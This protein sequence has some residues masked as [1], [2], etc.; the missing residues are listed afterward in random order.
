[1]LLL[2]VLSFAAHAGLPTVGCDFQHQ[3]CDW[4]L[5]ARGRGERLV[6][7]VKLEI[8]EMYKTFIATY[9]YTEGII[10]TQ[11]IVGDKQG[12]LVTGHTEVYHVTARQT[13]VYHVTARQT[14][15]YHVTVTKS[16]SDRIKYNCHF[17]VPPSDHVQ[18]RARDEEHSKHSKSESGVEGAEG[19]SASPV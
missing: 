1:M 5:A 15:V 2:N 18:P 14:Q 9:I 19:S 10:T 17:V 6:P 16:S 8:Q 4:L 7:H 11:E 12:T 3:V 13:Q